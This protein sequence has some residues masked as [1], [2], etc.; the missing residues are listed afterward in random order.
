ME[1]RSEKLK[2]PSPLQ[3][4]QLVNEEL[5]FKPKFKS[6]GRVLVLPCSAGP[7]TFPL[8]P[9]QPEFLP[10]LQTL[11]ESKPWAV[12]S[13]ICSR[14]HV[15]GRGT[16]SESRELSPC[17]LELCHPWLLQ[18]EHLLGSS[19]PPSLSL[20]GDSRCQWCVSPTLAAS[21]YPAHHQGRG[22]A[23]RMRSIL[24]SH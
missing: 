17:K 4:T 5:G 20:A 23:R 11:S 1:K 9:R 3:A 10:T 6:D 22:R 12:L 24:F 14:F 2:N 19:S 13:A 7:S 15:P 18:S 21:H 16:G 8:C